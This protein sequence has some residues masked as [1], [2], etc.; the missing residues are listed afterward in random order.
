MMSLQIFTFVWIC[1]T[2]K[3]DQI[4]LKLRT[5]F[6]ALEKNQLMYCTAFQQQRQSCELRLSDGTLKTIVFSV[7]TK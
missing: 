5:S 4:R 6:A 7:S 2:V 1:V 3:A